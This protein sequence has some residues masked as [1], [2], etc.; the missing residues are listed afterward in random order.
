MLNQLLTDSTGGLPF[1][2]GPDHGRVLISGEATGNA[3]SLMEFTVAPSG[4]NAGYGPH[5]HGEIDEVFVVRRGSIEFLVDEE[6]ATLTTGD[7]VRVPAGTRHGYRNTSDEA[8]ELLVWFSP[9]GFEQL[10]VTY[11]TDQ[12]SVDA[13]GF[14]DEATSRFNSTFEM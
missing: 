7:V 2:D 11:R 5:Q 1:E 10:F 13:N 4:E 9:G 6:V 12:P 3:Y 8:V 14:L